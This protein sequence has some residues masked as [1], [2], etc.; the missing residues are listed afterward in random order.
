MLYISCIIFS[1][2]KTQMEMG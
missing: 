2:S 1:V